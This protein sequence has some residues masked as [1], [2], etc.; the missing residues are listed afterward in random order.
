MT[1]EEIWVKLL[2]RSVTKLAGRVL[3]EQAKGFKVKPLVKK[4]E[5]LRRELREAELKVK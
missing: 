4:L 2:E 1:N 5:S 3:E